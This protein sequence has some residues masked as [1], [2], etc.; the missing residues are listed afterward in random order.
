MRFDNILETED[1]ARYYELGGEVIKALDGV[2]LKVRQGEY[3]SRARETHTL[4]YI[5]LYTQGEIVASN[6]A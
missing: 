2:T 3:L 4:N 6:M 1:Q 5:L